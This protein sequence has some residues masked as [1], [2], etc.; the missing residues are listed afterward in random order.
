MKWMPGI[1]F[2]RS[3]QHNAEAPAL[4]THSQHLI[5]PRAPLCR[6]RTFSYSPCMVRAVRYNLL[7]HEHRH[8]VYQLRQ[9]AA[10][11]AR[12]AG[13]RLLR[14]KDSLLGAI[15]IYVL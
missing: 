10:R 6:D 4:P 5:S 9:Q 14:S 2:Y 7:V 8:A 15:C 12:V 1:V 13:C 3:G 11:S